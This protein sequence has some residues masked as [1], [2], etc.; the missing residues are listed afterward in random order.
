MDRRVKHVLAPAFGRTRG[1]GDDGLV[2]RMRAPV[3]GLVP[4][5]TLYLAALLAT[6]S[7]LAT[8]NAIVEINLGAIGF[9]VPE[10]WIDPG[11]REAAL[12]G[13]IDTILLIPPVDSMDEASHGAF[14]PDGVVSIAI[15][16]RDDPALHWRALYVDGRIASAEERF[17][18]AT[19]EDITRAFDE[20][21]FDRLFGGAFASSGKSASRALHFVGSIPTSAHDTV[22]VAAR[23]DGSTRLYSISLT[24]RAD[25]KPIAAIITLRTMRPLN[26]GDFAL[27][28]VAIEILNSRAF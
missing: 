3:P 4:A 15:L 13:A 25:D 11:Y 6:E 28:G 1:P 14:K 18:I 23:I 12:G 22:A 17:E 7:A 8:D 24:I 10:D 9:S 19:A 27:I 21:P 16:L 2:V 5:A 20:L 26:A